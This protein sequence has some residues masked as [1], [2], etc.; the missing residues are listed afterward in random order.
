M[1][2]CRVKPS[3]SECRRCGDTAEYFDGTPIC[4]ECPLDITEQSYNHEKAEERMQ[5][6]KGGAE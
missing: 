2:T 1:R 6:L 4:A 3:A 5:T